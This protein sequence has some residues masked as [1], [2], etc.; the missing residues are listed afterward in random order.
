MY[1]RTLSIQSN[2]IKI[3]APNSSLTYHP[4]CLLPVGNCQCLLPSRQTCTVV[5][6]TVQQDPLLS[7]TVQQDSRMY[8]TVQQDPLL[9]LTV[10]RDS[11]LSVTVLL[12][13]H[14]L[15]GVSWHSMFSC[16]TSPIRSSLK[17][18]SSIKSNQRKTSHKLGNTNFCYFSCLWWKNKC[19]TA[20]CQN[21]GMLSNSAAHAAVCQAEWHPHIHPC[22][23][24]TY[25]SMSDFTSHDGTLRF[26][27]I[28]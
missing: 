24:C 4:I 3:K 5:R 2:Q 17:S 18:I 10:Q 23:S 22:L 11:C 16:L 25:C 21:N 1:T 14:G 7:L 8:L 6:M 13:H 27:V 12:D 28:V 26:S 20:F 19:W 15:S 9:S